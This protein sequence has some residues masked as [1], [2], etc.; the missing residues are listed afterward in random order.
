MR[1]IRRRINA[2]SPENSRD[3]LQRP[4]QEHPDRPRWEGDAP[5]PGKIRRRPTQGHLD[6][7][8]PTT[9]LSALSSARAS[10]MLPEFLVLSSPSRSPAGRMES[11][12]HAPLGHCVRNVSKG[13]SDSTVPDE[14]REPKPTEKKRAGTVRDLKPK[15]D[16]KGG[17]A[18]GGKSDKWLPRTEEVDFNL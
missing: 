6:R 8:G 15:A 10:T 1:R 7:I 12:N 17:A 11:E 18:N 9:E 14:T 13:L 4:M 3:G 16:P 5:P 2:H